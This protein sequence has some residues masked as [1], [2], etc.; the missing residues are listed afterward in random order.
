VTIR[1]LIAEDH[2]IVR[3]GIRLILERQDDM[4]VIGE[5][6]DG[7]AAVTLA[8]ELRPDVVCMDLNMPGIDGMEATRRIR[9]AH[10]AVAVIALTV[11]GSDEYFFEMIKAGAAGYVL[12]GAA[13]SDLVEAV[14]AAASGGSFLYPSLARKLVDDYVA[15]AHE[16]E[17]ADAVSNLSPRE[18]EILT[19]VAEGLSNKE[20]AERLVIGLSTVQTHYAH[21]LDK[22]GL[23][24]RGELIKYAI[25][26]GVID[27]ER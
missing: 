25:R 11:H 20:I 15:R 19:L 2:A 23:A 3:E 24:N 6:V 18:R 9:K 8:D 14:R 4:T 10:P 27:L 5:A 12:K 1:V 17:A 7:I 21:I 16:H 26:H 22:L 13:S